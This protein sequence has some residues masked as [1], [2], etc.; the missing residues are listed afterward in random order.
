MKGYIDLVIP[1]GGKSLV[2]KVDELSTV[3]YIDT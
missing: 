3:P 1:R 2:K